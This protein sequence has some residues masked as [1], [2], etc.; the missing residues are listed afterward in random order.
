MRSPSF[1]SARYYVLFTVDFSGWRVVHFMKSKSEVPAL[2]RLFIASLLNETGNTVHT[3]RSD[4]G[5]EYEGN[6]FK[7]YLG[8]KGIRHETSA[9]YTPGQNGV[10]ER[11]NRTIMDGAHSMLLA[12]SLPPSLWVEAVAYLVFIRNRFLSSTGTITPFEAWN[13][14]K[15][16]VSNIPIFGSRAFEGRPIV[17]NSTR[18]VW[19]GQLLESA[20][21]K[22]RLVSTFPLNQHESLSATM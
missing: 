16:D 7:K 10:A 18:D 19:K 12:S 6:Y 3:L 9:A 14:R 21:H 5:G 22:R 4:N 1:G 8:E 13:N 20:I 2:F 17:K 15:P 11:G